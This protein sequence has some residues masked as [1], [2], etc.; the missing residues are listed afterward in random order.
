MS[1]LG[2]EHTEDGELINMHS[3]KDINVF[4][5]HDETIEI[6]N[7]RTIKVVNGKHT[8]TIKGDTTIKI[9]DGNLDHDV[10]SGTAKYHVKGKIEELYDDSQATLAKNAI[11]I[12]SGTAHIYIHG[13]TSIQLHVGA[14]QLWMDSGGGILLKGNHI[15]IVGAQKVE[16]KGGE[17]VSHA[18]TMHEIS[19]ANVKSTGSS[20]N[21]VQGAAV[22]LNP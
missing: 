20:T 5:A 9:T 18:D 10:A 7:D 22:L 3:D 4:A 19:G 14:S 2:I 12:T 16:I 17:V 13:C 8:E 21:T 6:T 15:Q 1:D 11:S